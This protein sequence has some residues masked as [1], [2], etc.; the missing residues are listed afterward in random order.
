MEDSQTEMASEIYHL[1]EDKNTLKLK[2]DENVKVLSQSKTALS[3]LGAKHAEL[4]V[5]KNLRGE[6]LLKQGPMER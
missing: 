1:T 4:Q 2:Y 5:V 3:E 6:N